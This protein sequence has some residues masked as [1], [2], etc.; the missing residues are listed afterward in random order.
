MIN[1]KPLAEHLMIKAVKEDTITSGGIHLPMKTRKDSPIKGLV[2]KVGVGKLLP[3]GSRMAIAVKEGD[4]ILF[5]EYA[6]KDA[7]M[8]DGAEYLFIQEQDIY[9]VLGGN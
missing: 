2:I 5:N 7:F 4:V 3:N 8:L 6:T 1:V 9:A